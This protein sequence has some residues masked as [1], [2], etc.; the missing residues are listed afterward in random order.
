MIVREGPAVG[1]LSSET[2][3]MFI[4]LDY[5][6]TLDAL[7]ELETVPV[8]VD[9]LVTNPGRL[10]RPGHLRSSDT[11][12]L[13]YREPDRA[14]DRPIDEAAWHARIKDWKRRDKCCFR[15]E[16][17]DRGLLLSRNRFRSA[18]WDADSLVIDM[19]AFRH[20]IS[21]LYRRDGQ[22]AKQLENMLKK[23]REVQ[24]K[25]AESQDQ[26]GAASTTLG[27]F[28]ER[29][30]KRVFATPQ[31]RESTEALVELYRDR[32]LL[33]GGR[34][35]DLSCS[36]PKSRE[37]WAGAP[38]PEDPAN[39]GIALPWLGRSYFD[40]RVVL[41]GMNFNNF[42]GLAAHYYV[43]EDHIRSMEEGKRGKN[44]EAFS[45]GAM[46]YLRVVLANMDR[47]EIPAD[48]DSVSNEELAALW[49]RCAYAQTIK[50]APGTER[51]NPTDAMIANCPEF[52]L[53]EE[54]EVLKP[55][56]I[57][58]FG[59]SDLRDVVRPWSVAEDGY[60]LEEGPHLE[61]N[62]AVIGGR[63]VTLF[64]LNHP[65]SQNSHYVS[66]SLGQLAESLRRWPIR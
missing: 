38:D 54:L 33:P 53:K 30:E 4:C 3:G 1:V 22:P 17:G 26:Q 46:Q 16:P 35:V 20:R 34:D 27:D 42:G 56:A 65:S 2:S 23:F 52:L 28:L 62:R 59:R 37:C 40:A 50:C 19:E 49:E 25:R 43:C 5:E 21:P 11:G 60:G 14:S 47:E 24:M 29:W 39:S 41:L 44:G 12:I 32:N 8:V 63:D 66:D 48:L 57:L 64:S 13:R 10:Y 15:L 9:S 18:R 61:R 6:Q 55:S 45:R 31:H 58:L 51:S 7:E 36:C